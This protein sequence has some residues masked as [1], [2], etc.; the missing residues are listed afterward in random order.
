MVFAPLSQLQSIPNQSLSTAQKL[1]QLMKG[2][3]LKKVEK[4]ESVCIPSFKV[5]ASN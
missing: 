2:I 3:D 1:R 4:F 5:R